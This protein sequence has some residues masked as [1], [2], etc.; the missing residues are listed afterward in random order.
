M[1]RA[2]VTLASLLGS[3]NFL[4]ADDQPPMAMAVWALDADGAN[5]REIGA[6]PGYPIINSPEVSPNGKWVAVD[7]WKIG[8][9]NVDAHV[10]LLNVETRETRDL[11]PG[12]MPSWSA[13]G[14]WVAISKYA[15]HGV[16][17]RNVNT[18]AEQIMDGAG[19]AIQLSPDG[20]QAAYIRGGN[21][22]VVDEFA[23][24]TQREY[25]PAKEDP[26]RYIMHNARWS[27]DSRRIA[28]LGWRTSGKK[29]IA[30]LTLDSQNPELLVLCDA[31]NV[32]PDIAWHPQDGR[33]TFPG[34][35]DKQ[36]RK[37]GQILTA[38]ADHPGDAMPLPGQPPDR[39]NRGMCWTADGKTLIF[40]SNAAP[41]WW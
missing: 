16:Y 19:W 26:Y 12:C 7:G 10:L 38:T 22:I 25:V 34:K 1:L 23:T 29:E 20:G 4:P 40:V 9:K 30:I 32:D 31:S 8:Q 15:P 36:A 21:K 35:V 2:V 41:P 14:E 33:I 3:A 17:M 27:P 6:I 5:A 24:N 28:F 18:D 13:D 37:P 39:T 11:G